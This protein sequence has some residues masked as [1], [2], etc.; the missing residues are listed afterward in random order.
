MRVFVR[1]LMMIAMAA[2]WIALLRA[3]IDWPKG[4]IALAET[5]EVSRHS[6]ADTSSLDQELKD[7]MQATEEKFSQADQRL[8]ALEKNTADISASLAR[9]DERSGIIRDVLIAILAA[10]AVLVTERFLDRAGRRS[11]TPAR[12]ES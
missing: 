10:L 12:R 7:H 5:P 4:Y 8:S 2:I 6:S 11:A 3:T 1:L 9:L